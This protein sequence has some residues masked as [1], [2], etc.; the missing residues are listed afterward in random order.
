MASLQVASII[1]QLIATASVAVSI[2]RVILFGERQP[3]H[4]FLFAFGRTELLYM[5]MAIA[6]TLFT[7]IAIALVLVPFVTLI[8]GGDPIAY[9]S[10]LFPKAGGKPGSANLGG[11]AAGYFLAWIFAGYFMLRLAV[12]PPAIVATKRLSLGD[13]WQLTKGNVLRLFGLFLLP[14]LVMWFPI[15]LAVAAYWYVNAPHEPPPAAATPS[16]QTTPVPA[17]SHLTSAALAAMTSMQL[18]L[19][20]T[21][22]STDPMGTE[23]KTP[24][25][26]EQIDG[27]PIAPFFNLWLFQFFFEIYLTAFG[28]ALLSYSYKALMGID[29]GE[30]IQT[31]D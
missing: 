11:L 25:A 17:G 9:L 6:S 20:G 29:A 8:S 14:L 3:G 18:A 23:E 31:P 21:P 26:H 2:H 27:L 12:W 4:Y 24:P 7:V 5:S 10:S 15:V 13:A 30:P 19:Q 28:V 22:P 1:L 16:E